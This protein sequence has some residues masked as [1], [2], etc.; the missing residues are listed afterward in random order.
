MKKFFCSRK[1][2]IF[3][4]LNSFFNKFSFLPHIL[5]TFLLHFWES[6]AESESK[7]GDEKCWCETGKIKQGD[8]RRKEVKIKYQ[9]LTTTC[10]TERIFCKINLIRALHRPRNIYFLFSVGNFWRKNTQQEKWR[11]WMKERNN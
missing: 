11:G 8:E 7:T 6:R 10:T 3:L 2:L 4:F 1:K 5:L 9:K